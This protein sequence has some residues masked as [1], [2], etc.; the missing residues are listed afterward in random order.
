[1][2]LHGSLLFDINS[3]EDLPDMESWIAKIVDGKGIYEMKS[4]L[5]K[6]SSI[7]FFNRWS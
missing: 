1:M 3:A 4:N 7:F 6:L 5:L 2:F